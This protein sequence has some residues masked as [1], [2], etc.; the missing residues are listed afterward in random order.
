MAKF[1][2]MFRSQVL[3][4]EVLIHRLC[5]WFLVVVAKVVDKVVDK[6]ADRDWRA[7]ITRAPYVVTGDSGEVG[8]TSGRKWRDRD[9]GRRNRVRQN[10]HDLPPPSPQVLT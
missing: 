8:Q 6:E 10:T 5:W 2:P 3:G 1:L 9:G 7:G 4:M